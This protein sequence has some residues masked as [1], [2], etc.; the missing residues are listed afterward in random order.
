MN[1]SDSSRQDA[2]GNT[3]NGEKYF[4][5]E[6]PLLGVSLTDY[7]KLRLSYC[8]LRVSREQFAWINN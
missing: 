3:S 8:L 7:T 5:L 2:L 1:H 6:I 4:P